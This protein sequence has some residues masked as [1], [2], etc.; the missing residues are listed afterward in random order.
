MISADKRCAIT[1]LSRG[2]RMCASG[3]FAALTGAGLSAPAAVFPPIRHRKSQVVPATPPPAAA[4]PWASTPLV[5]IPMEWIP[6]LWNGYQ[7]N[8][9]YFNALHTNPFHTN[10]FHTNG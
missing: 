10:P 7:W 4:T 6:F 8:G 3:H 9:M 1:G 5:S 2:E